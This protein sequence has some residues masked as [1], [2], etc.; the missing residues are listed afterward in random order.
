MESNIGLTLV[1]CLG[2]F[3]IGWLF[4]ILAGDQLNRIHKHLE[5]ILF[6]LFIVL[7]VFA[8]VSPVIVDSQDWQYSKEP[9]A[10]EHIVCLN[11]N[12][13]VSGR[14]YV[15]RGYFNED[16]YYQYMVKLSSGGMVANKVRSTNTTIYYDSE[17]PRVEWYTKRK[18]W[19]WMYEEKTYHKLYVP[20]G[21][22]S[23]DFSIDLQ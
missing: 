2:I 23:D 20:E 17:D 7:I 11:D 9:Y 6:I 4:V 3:V 15:K 1:I 8:F 12:N 14:M 16:L 22:I 21:T 10:I 18:Q 5:S 13:M 19:L